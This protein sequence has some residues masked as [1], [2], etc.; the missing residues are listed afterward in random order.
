MNSSEYSNDGLRVVVYRKS[1]EINMLDFADSRAA[2][3]KNLFVRPIEKR[4]IYQLSWL[5][6]HLQSSENSINK[7]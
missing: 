6:T 7:T 4:V 1:P 5:I 3:K 2:G